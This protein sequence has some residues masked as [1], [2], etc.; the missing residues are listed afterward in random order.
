MTHLSMQNMN[1]VGRVMGRRISRPG[2]M[3]LSDVV[4]DMQNPVS[5]DD[6]GQDP[7]GL[8]PD[9][10]TDW[11]QPPLRK[12]EVDTQRGTPPPGQYRRAYSA[13]RASSP[14]TPDNDARDLTNSFTGKP[15]R[16]LPRRNYPG[17]FPHT[18]I[19]YEELRPAVGPEMGPTPSGWAATPTERDLRARAEN[20][21]QPVPWVAEDNMTH[22]ISG[23]A[24]LHD[25]GRLRFGN[26]QS[27]A[28]LHKRVVFAMARHHN[29]RRGLFGLGQIDSEGRDSSGF[30][31]DA[32]LAQAIAND[33]A[34]SA[35]AGA[36]TKQAVTA[37]AQGASPSTIDQIINFGAKAATAALQ[38]S[39]K[40]PK[41]AVQQASMLP[42]AGATPWVIGGL[43]VAA[44]GAAAVALKSGKG[45]G[46]RR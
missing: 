42:G 1:G 37:Q 44:L 45:G 31:T 41:P 33:S 30:V 8:R 29:A 2:V 10:G 39:G 18:W 46:R 6:L 14:V 20:G 4:P 12:D 36:V 26:G 27:T 22:D 25:L 34:A 24:S 17:Q 35:A 9:Y 13:Y 28:E 15:L 16:Q 32:S 19:P 38:A 40:M 43:A 3:G 21:G 23:F 5:E 7:K 11:I